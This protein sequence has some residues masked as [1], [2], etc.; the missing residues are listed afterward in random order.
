M[1][2][3]VLGIIPSPLTPIIENQGFN[4]IE[5]ADPVDTKYLKEHSIEYAVSYRY[6]HIIRKAVI[7]YLNGNIIN[8]HVSFLPWNR[9][10]DPNLWS[11]L[12]NT[13]NLN[14]N[15]KGLVDCPLLAYTPSNKDLGYASITSEAIAKGYEQVLSL[16]GCNPA[17]LNFLHTLRGEDGCAYLKADPDKIKLS[18]QNKEE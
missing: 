16:L 8:L 9:G 1:T 15:L 11:F 6:R 14:E 17:E 7:E 12:E 13:P 4:V 10:A 18:E 2:I 5:Y 3:L